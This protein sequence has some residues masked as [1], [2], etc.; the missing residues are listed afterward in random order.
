Y[1]LAL[2][3]PTLG[4]RV[5]FVYAGMTGIAAIP[6]ALAM[7]ALSYSRRSSLLNRGGLP[8]L[9][10]LPAVTAALTWTNEYHHFIFGPFR[11]AQGSGVLLPA[12][13]PGFW[14]LY[15]VY[16]S[17]VI[18]GCIASLLT[19]LT[20]KQGLEKQEI[21]LLLI[22]LIVPPLVAIYFFAHL[23]HLQSPD[24][25]PTSFAFAAL[26]S[27]YAIFRYRSPHTSALESSSKYIELDFKIQ[28]VRALTVVLIPTFT[29]FTA[30][31]L[32]AGWFFAGVI[33]ILFL[34]TIIVFA[35]LIVNSAS[36]EATNRLFKFA[37]AL[38]V[39]LLWALC[40]YFLSRD[41]GSGTILWS[42]TIPLFCLLALGPNWGLVMSLAYQAVSVAASYIMGSF[43]SVYFSSFGVR[44]VVVYLILAISLFYLDKK[45]LEFLRKTTSQRDSLLDSDRRY[46]WATESGAVGVWDLDAAGQK[47]DLDQN[48]FKILGYESWLRISSLPE[49]LELCPESNRPQARLD[50]RSLIGAGMERASFEMPLLHRQGGTSWFLIRGQM[51]EGVGEHANSIFGTIT[52]ITERKRAD[53][54][55][56]LL[57]AQLRHSQK[58]EAVGTLAGGIAHEFNNL[59]AAI[60]GYAELA[61]DKAEGQPELSENL[62]QITMA[63]RRARDLISQLLTFSR[64]DVPEVRPLEINNEILASQQMLRRLLP[65]AVTIKTN[66]APDLKMVEAS[67]SHVNQLLV[68]L[69]S[70]AAHAMPEGGTLS[71]FTKNVTAAGLPCSTC[72][73]TMFGDYV[74][75]TVADTGHGMDQET[76]QRIFEP[77]FTTKE[78][79]SGTGLG[80][81]VVHGIIRSYHGHTICQSEV[82]R[83][84]TFLVYLPAYVAGLDQPQ[85]SE[86]DSAPLPGG[87]ETILWVDDENFLCEMGRQSLTGMGYHVLTAESGEAALSIYKKKAK[88]ISLVVLDLGMPGMGGQKC[89]RALR[90][91]NPRAKVVVLSGYTAGD[92]QKKA[93]AS[94]AAAF[95]T[96]PAPKDQLLRTVRAVL[97][98]Q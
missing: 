37:V 22:G 89:L 77:F 36:P 24:P 35:T 64:K 71:I 54:D 61:Q 68:N 7:L 58:M 4:Y 19:S 90:E 98:G 94:G 32:N 43:D 55:R 17:L 53:E 97:D 3:L 45:R 56:A 21:R 87:S 85:P 47:M 33:D 52:D 39:G 44:Y 34:V 40:I 93:M 72:G 49:L 59:L 82:G 96:K 67:V 51:V 60:M 18:I 8:W 28:V 30:I 12:L 76:V 74:R 2:K 26:L 20:H 81:S 57:E 41:L 31:N 9:F 75:L 25:T 5:P 63:S 62:D 16:P 91:L 11:I 83:G 86:A 23:I 70:N 88:S 92:H 1:G 13:M 80:L 84:T 48:I 6:A 95:L 29:Y 27:I 73:E 66:L 10:V 69:V 50:W 42:L 15:V 46:R 65:R 38:S 14:V 78:V 79:G